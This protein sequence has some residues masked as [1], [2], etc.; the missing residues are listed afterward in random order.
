MSGA[1]A[2]GRKD[3]ADRHVRLYE[4]M[5]K[6]P[7]WRALDTVARCAYIELARRYAGPGSNN[8]RIPFSVREMAAALNASKATA[9]RALLRL[10]AHGFVVEMKRGAFSLKARHSSEW[11]LTEF[12]C[13]VSRA[14]ASKDFARWK[15][16]TGSSEGPNGCRYEPERVAA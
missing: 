14:A 7:A 13:D 12:P 15:Q 2:K 11:R 1:N 4:W 6:M 16:N 5:T 8:G 9:R 10:Q 3:R